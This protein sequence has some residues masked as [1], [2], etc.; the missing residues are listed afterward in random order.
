LI[1]RQCNAPRT[2]EF[3]FYVKFNK[4]CKVTNCGTKYASSVIDIMM[5]NNLNYEKITEVLDL[6]Y[7]DHLP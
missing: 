4:Y 1:E 3:I 5:I 2:A 6:G 7:S